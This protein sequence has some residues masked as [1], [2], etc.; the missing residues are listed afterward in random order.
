[1]DEDADDE[2]FNEGEEGDDEGGDGEIEEG[3][4][5]GGVGMFGDGFV[6]ACEENRERSL[7]KITKEM[8]GALLIDFKIV[9][10]F[11]A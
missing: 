4:G 10:S 8:F 3:D 9:V 2:G 11:I 6:E 5:L 1:M 7:G